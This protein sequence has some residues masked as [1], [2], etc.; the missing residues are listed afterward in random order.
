[1]GYPHK[2]IRYGENLVQKQTQE[3]DSITFSNFEKFIANRGIV[4]Q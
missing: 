2:M 3:Y 4:I 1:M